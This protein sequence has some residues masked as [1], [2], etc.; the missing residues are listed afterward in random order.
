[1]PVLLSS[2][3]FPSCSVSPCLRGT[4]VTRVFRAA[5]LVREVDTLALILLFVPAVVMR[6][7][8]S[9]QQVADELLAADRA[10]SAASAKT[11][12]VSGL[13]AM[14]ADDVVDAQLRRHRR[15]IARRRS[16]RCARIRSNTGAKIEWTPARVGISG[17]GRHGFTAG[18]MTMQ[19]A[20]GDVSA[21]EVPG[22]LGKASGR[23]GGCWPTSAAAKA[24]PPAMSRWLRAAEADRRT[25]KDAAAIEQYR[26]SL[27][28]AET[29]F[30][31]EAQKIGIGAAF[32]QVR[33]P[34]RHQPGRP[35]RRRRS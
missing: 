20:D 15:R 22:L 2:L 24:A 7:T 30:S 26:K 16:R 28:D 25:A 33:Q 32:T 19:R 3:A 5:N 11:D 4:S 14:F 29:A 10:F 35:G 23:V 13:S 31:N 12:L 6:Q 17:D 21:A 18:F 1:M 27:A 8:T 9:P 34:R